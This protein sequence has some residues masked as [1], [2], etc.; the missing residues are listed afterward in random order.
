MDT[1]V[2]LRTA[3]GGA[4]KIAPPLNRN[5]PQPWPTATTVTALRKAILDCAHQAT[6]A[7]PTDTDA[8]L[9]CFIAK[10]SG[11]MEGLGERELDAALWNLMTSHRQP[12]APGEPPTSDVQLGMDWWNGLTE[13]RRAYWLSKAV[14]AVPY[15]AWMAFRAA[16]DDLATNG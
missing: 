10:L 4:L 15:A 12:P 14:S 13:E 16:E 8:R 9:H 2:R 7:E 5:I 3:A 6:T 11:T 1:S